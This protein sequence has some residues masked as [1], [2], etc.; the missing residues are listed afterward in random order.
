VLFVAVIKVFAVPRIY[1]LHGKGVRQSSER[2]KV[3][4]ALYA[5]SFS[6]ADVIHLSPALFEDVGLFVPHDR[7]FAV[8]NGILG[9][10]SA[11]CRAGQAEA[12]PP[13]IGFISSMLAQKGP[14]ILL[15]ALSLLQQRG[16][17][18][19]AEF[20]GAWREQTVQEAFVQMIAYNRLSD[21]VRYVGPVTG[22]DKHRFFL[23]SQILAY[24]TREDAFPLVAIEAMAYGLPLV[25]SR[26]GSLVEIVDEGKTGYLVPKNDSNALADGL[27]RLLENPDLMIQMGRAGRERYERNYT[28]QIF[29]QRLA[30]VLLDSVARAGGR[31]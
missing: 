15:E 8:P 20:A 18:F 21:R 19:R 6:D 11:P 16:I 5:W 29:E 14:L 13:Q 26:E 23:R 24:P 31:P 25:A 7:L 12:G 9:P 28:L 2:S 27:Q 1:H 4:R 22:P 17:P 30:K 3:L 10:P